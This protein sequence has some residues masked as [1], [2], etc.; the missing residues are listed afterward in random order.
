MSEVYEWKWCHNCGTSTPHED[1]FCMECGCLPGHYEEEY[2]DA[3]GE[4]PIVEVNQIEKCATN[5]NHG[6]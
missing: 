1:N 4:G 5:Q 6:G 3:E 2:E